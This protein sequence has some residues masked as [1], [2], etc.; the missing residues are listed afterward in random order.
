[1][2]FKR[3]MAGPASSPGQSFFSIERVVVLVSP[4]F[5]A[6]S[7]WLAGVVASNIPFAPP[8]D[9]AAIE[10]VMIAAF[11]SLAGI[12]I[13]WL[14]GRQLPAIAGL[15]PPVPIPQAELD[16]LYNQIQTY[17]QTHPE[18]FQGPAGTP[19]T[20]EAITVE[21]EAAVRRVLAGVGSQGSPAPVV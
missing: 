14:H 3:G 4:F 20:Q 12:I 13:K 7:V 19:A 16:V 18:S 8:L 10:G 9:P 17:I 15:T 5:L 11:L 21:A 6:A 2:P 1:M